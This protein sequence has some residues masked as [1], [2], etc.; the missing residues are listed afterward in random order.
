MNR[1]I[2]I[3]FSYI[4]L[5]DSGSYYTSSHDLLDELLNETVS[6]ITLE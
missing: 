3:L 4:I 6:K 2:A 5:T 1:A